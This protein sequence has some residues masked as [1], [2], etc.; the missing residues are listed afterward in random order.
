MSLR[1]GDKVSDLGRKE[2]SG[3][4]VRSSTLSQV[5][6]LG[7]GVTTGGNTVFINGHKDL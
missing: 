7:R 5:T 6:G 3:K 1:V 4:V 2:T